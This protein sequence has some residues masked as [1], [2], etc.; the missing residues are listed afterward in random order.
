MATFHIP[1]S[2]AEFQRISRFRAHVQQD[3]QEFF[4]RADCQQ[5]SAAR[6][7]KL[8]TPGKLHAGK[9]LLNKF[10]SLA[11]NQNLATQILVKNW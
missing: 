10:P 6:T 5:I 3:K 9:L 4:F 2:R 8:N 1:Y 7:Q 11:N